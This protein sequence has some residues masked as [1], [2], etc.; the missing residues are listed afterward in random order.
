M[1][2][3]HV[4]LCAVLQSPRV[5]GGDLGIRLFYT[6]QLTVLSLGSQECWRPQTARRWRS[7]VPGSAVA[8]IRLNDRILQALANSDH[9]PGAERASAVGATPALPQV[10]VPTA[11]IITTLFLISVCFKFA[12]ALGPAAGCESDRAFTSSQRSCLLGA[13]AVGVGNWD[14]MTA[15]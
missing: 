14:Q 9:R 12:I 8:S 15:R 13:S 6:Q 4:Q 10:C 1:P 7:C 3:Q 11:R 5:V 2:A